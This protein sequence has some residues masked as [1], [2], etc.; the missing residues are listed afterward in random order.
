MP[1]FRTAALAP[2]VL[3]ALMSC[4]LSHERQAQTIQ[5]EWPAADIRKLELVSDN[6][7]MEIVAGSD[8]KI[9]MTATVERWSRRRDVEA[10]EKLVESRVED[11]T[12]HIGQ[13]R[14]GH[15]RIVILPFVGSGSASVAYRLEV[16]RSLALA[17]TNVNGRIEVEG[18]SGPAVLRSVNGTIR[19]TKPS[20]E[21][22]AK[23]VN[24]RVRVRFTEEFQGARLSTV[25]GS[26][27]ISVPSNASFNT[28]V[29]QVN[30]S[31]TSNVPMTVSSRRGGDLDASVN[32]GTYSLELSTVNGS[33]TV[34]RRN[35]GS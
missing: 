26:I 6:G 18:V 7:A 22:A 15:R 28:D 17:L 11:G 14:S 21:L 30:G 9:S 20:G 34:E 31:F 27:S 4:E 10:I 5:R 13:K 29:S 35:S 33:I 2:L 32:G 23:T 24:G 3:L 12:L 19:V 25:N 16:P 1:R 8:S